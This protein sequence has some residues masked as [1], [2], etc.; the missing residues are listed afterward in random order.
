MPKLNLSEKN[1]NNLN[2]TTSKATTI[3]TSSSSASKQ[4][5]NEA[6]S[7]DGKIQKEDSSN[8][9]TPSEVLRGGN[10]VIFLETT[11]RMEPPSLVLCVIESAARVYK[12][13]PV[14]YFM[15]GLKEINSE[16][17]KN[18]YL[19]VFSSIKNIYIFPLKMEEVFAE[20]PLLPWYN[21]VD[22]KREVY[23]THVSADGCRL[24][25]IWKH[26]GIYLDTDIISLQQIPHQDFL[27]REGSGSFGNSAFGFSPHYDFAWKCMEDFVRNYRGE[28]WGYQGPTLL[29][30]IAM[31]MCTFPKD[32]TN[33][34]ICGNITGLKSDRLYPLLYPSWQRYYE[35]WDKEPTFNE[36]YGVHLW[37]YMNRNEHK[38]MVPRSNTLV[39]H[40]YQNN[41]PSTYDLVAKQTNA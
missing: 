40:L 32:S 13:R 16:E 22:P 41:C 3:S 7:K 11:D 12:D 28:I 15:K 27:A 29:T 37:S 14:V 24:A 26:G 34:F 19:P 17:A 25:L 9:L 8:H 33:D 23:W 30:R 31:Q 38:S 39:E 5:V 18:K 36:S 6:D 20:T 4:S 35:V 2:I 10:G 21:K 1:M